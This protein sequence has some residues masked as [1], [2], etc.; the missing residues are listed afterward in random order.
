MPFMF[1]TYMLAD[2]DKI[3]IWEILL[4]Y[5]ICSVQSYIFYIFTC[6]TNKQKVCAYL[7]VEVRL[8]KNGMINSCRPTYRP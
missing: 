8:Q 1:Y 4:E 3:Q 6:T 5:C 2:V 7:H